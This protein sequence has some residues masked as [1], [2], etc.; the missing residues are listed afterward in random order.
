MLP[1]PDPFAPPTVHLPPTALLVA[2]AVAAATAVVMAV[3][4]RAWWRRH[5][6]GR[7]AGGGVVLHVQ[8]PPE[9]EPDG[10][11]GFFQL[12]AVAAVPWWKRLIYGQPHIAF[13]YAWNGP[14]LDIR[15]WVP[16]TL[17]ARSIADG[18]RGAWPA[19]TVTAHP[20]APALPPEAN[21]VEAGVIVLGDSH[22][23]AVRADAV[24]DP[25][26][27]LLAALSGLQTGEYALVQ[28]LA[29]P[30]PRRRILRLRRRALGHRSGGWGW[31][32]ALADLFLP[33]PS[34]TGKRSHVPAPPD[35]W[36]RRVGQRDLD[37]SAG[38]MLEV[39]V[40][41]AVATTRRGD[42]VSLRTR[43]RGLANAAATALAAHSGPDAVRR[44]RLMVGLVRAIDE[45]RMV[46]GALATP[47]EAAVLAHLPYDAVVPQLVR[48]GARIVPAGI[49]IPR[50]G[51]GTKTLGTAAADGRTVAL[52]VSDARHHM[53]VVGSTG[54]GKSTLLLNMILADIKAGRGVIVIDPKGDLVADIL[55][56]LDPAVLGDRLV[57]IDP[58]Q[59]N[60]PGLNPLSGDD[61]DL[62]VDHLVGICRRIFERH[63]GPRADD[64]LR[65]ALLTLLRVPAATLKHLPSLLSQKSF[66]APIV[67]DIDDPAGLGGFWQW[68]DNLSPAFQAQVIGPVLSRIRALLTREFVRATLGAPTT[69]FDMSRVLDGGILLARLPKGQ[70]GDDTSSLMGSIIVAK[71]WQAATHRTTLAEHQRLDATLYLDEA[72]NFLNLPRSLDDVLAEARGYRLSMVLAHQ[73]MAQ[74]PRE[75]Q[76]A[77]SANARNKIYFTTSP[78]DAHLLA[79]HT[80]PHLSEHD[81]SHLDAFTAACRLVAD[82]KEQPAFTLSTTPAPPRVRDHRRRNRGGHSGQH[83]SPVTPPTDPAS[84]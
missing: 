82:G 28:V 72:H 17:S 9:V 10:A 8:A 32:A 3:A 48:A 63:W 73:H 13:E 40:R 12:V 81:L 58:D 47:A 5:L 45:R 6:A 64:V 62:V 15:V 66:R 26:R 59:P 77:I 65:S 27:L 1:T 79:R 22:T 78:E 25:A 57:V 33:G 37:R 23:A 61:P 56:R 76:F 30:A 84:A 29:R 20:A 74:L 44:S 18:I 39:A 52:N 50:G 53:H 35:A 24:A 36:Q 16:A 80:N 55:D 11:I 68:Y 60:P 42:R 54:V 7:H 43:M 41:Y 69:T 75:L 71:A 38:A 21:H 70:L 49:A 4:A 2:L 46:S 67:A 14:A 31:G 19:A 34:D 83:P 51:R